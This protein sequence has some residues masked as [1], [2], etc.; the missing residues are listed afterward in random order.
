MYYFKRKVNIAVMLR[1]GILFINKC[2]STNL[3]VKLKLI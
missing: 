3:K 2:I 1:T